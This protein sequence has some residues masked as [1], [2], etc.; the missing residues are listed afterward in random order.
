MTVP[1]PPLATG[2]RVQLRDLAHIAET[3]HRYGTVVS[4]GDPEAMVHFDQ[5]IEPVAI[6][7]WRIWPAD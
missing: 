4:D 1:T 7:R 6:D 5:Q 3:K 2:Q